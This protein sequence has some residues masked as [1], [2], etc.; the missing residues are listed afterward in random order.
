M[1]HIKKNKE[2]LNKYISNIIKYKKIEFSKYFY[3]IVIKK[4]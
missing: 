4:Q 3:K 1:F 2:N